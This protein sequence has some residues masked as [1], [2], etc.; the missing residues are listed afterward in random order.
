MNNERVDPGARMGKKIRIRYAHLKLIF[1]EL[2]NSFGLKI[3]KF[4]DAHPDLVN[5]GSGIRDGKNR[6]L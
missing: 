6:Y 2:R 5:P 4:F 3:F 1:R